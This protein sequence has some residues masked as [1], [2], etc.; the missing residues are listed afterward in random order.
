MSK[1]FTYQ[2]KRLKTWNPFTGC[3]FNCSYCWARKLAE[4]KLKNSYPNG[5]IPEF[6][7]DRF[8]KRFKP[9]DFV[10][11]CS[12]GDISFAPFIVLDNVIR[13]ALK[14]PDTKFLLCTKDPAR[15]RQFATIPNNIYLG[16]T[17]ETT[18]DFAVSYAPAVR[19]R[20]SAMM[21]LYHQKKFLSIEP[22]MDF[23]LMQFVWWIED[24]KPEIVEIGADNYN[25]QLPE[26]EPQ[27]VRNLL[28]HL[29]QIC[30]TVIEKQGLERLLQ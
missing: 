15:Y 2:G 30:P 25:N 10:F 6:H 11:V 22:I 14:C 16:T 17:I 9:N 27:K 13:I 28:N 5:F 8:N 18:E 24:I 26:P 21:G 20:Y 19:E 1:M 12:M 7:P 4:G 23:D 29:R 3:N